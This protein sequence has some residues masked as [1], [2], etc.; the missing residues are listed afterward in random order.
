MGHVHGEP[1]PM[2]GGSYQAISL[3]FDALGKQKKLDSNQADFSR[4]FVLADQ[5]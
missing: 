4:P 1:P 5:P 3:R 2:F